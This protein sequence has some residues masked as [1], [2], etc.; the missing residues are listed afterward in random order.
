MQPFLSS[1]FTEMGYNHETGVLRVKFT[2]GAIY[3]YRNVPDKLWSLFCNIDGTNNRLV[4]SA[5]PEAQISLGRVFYYTI[6]CNPRDYPF[7]E[8]KEDGTKPHGTPE[9]AP[10]QPEPPKKSTGNGE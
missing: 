6:Q 7:T 4:N 10:A 2:R 5:M 3:E 1:M 9:A 8:I